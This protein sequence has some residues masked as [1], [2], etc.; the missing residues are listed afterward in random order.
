MLQST[1]T[2]WLVSVSPG[3][4]CSTIGRIIASH[5]A[6]C[7]QT[8]ISIKKATIIWIII[9]ATTRR[10]IRES[11]TLGSMRNRVSTSLFTYKIFTLFDAGILLVVDLL[12]ISA[13]WLC[14]SE[15]QRLFLSYNISLVQ[16]SHVQC[17]L[18]YRTLPQK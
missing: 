5:Q 6:S 15:M 2:I 4:V 16:M 17:Q 14:Y 13:L 8:H 3:Q 9:V 18:Y 11:L 7:S 1:H 10:S 12:N